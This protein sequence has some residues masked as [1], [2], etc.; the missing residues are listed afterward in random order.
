MKHPYA[1]HRAQ[2]TLNHSAPPICDGACNIGDLNANFAPDPGFWSKCAHYTRP[3]MSA[4]PE[5]LTR[6]HVRPFQPV[7]VERDKQVGVGLR[8]PMNLTGRMMVVPP[9]ALGLIHA[10]QGEQTLEQLSEAS[11]V[12]VEQL[13]QLV[14]NL[15][16]SG[17][18]WGPTFDRLEREAME[19]TRAAGAF[20]ASGSKF[21]GDTR[22]AASERIGSLLSEAEDA[23][24]GTGVLGIIAPHLDLERGGANYAAAYKVVAG[25]ARPDRV[26]VLGT[27]HFGLGDGVVATRL[28]QDSPF[29]IIPSDPAIAGLLERALGDRL[30][31][32]EA[33]FLGE[34]SVQ[35]HI[36]WIAHT[37]PG[38]P[39]F[40]ALVPDPMRAMIADDGAR[41]SFAEF[42]AALRDAIASVSG[43]TLVVS[44][45]DLS[46]VGPAFGD[47]GPVGAQVRKQVE[48]IDR[49]LLAEYASGDV[50]AF[51]QSV[52]GAGNATRWCSVG[53]M[54]V[55]LSATEGTP[56][57]IQ[58]GQ[59]PES[60]DPQGTALITSAAMALMA[61]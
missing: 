58:Y 16:E 5:H 45:A 32:D 44:S 57:L 61:D 60:L 59:S 8:D 38:V 53:N 47:P 6:P 31:K 50:E 15:D 7:G 26:I 22:E 39:V 2:G 54:A 14:S 4:A 34:H 52:R 12:P 49:G 36:P 33:D 41:A 42:R 17:L 46:H 24:L 11:K 9:Q 1:H 29:G 20:P 3:A 35:F 23:E 30:F 51:I 43:R 21:A 18:L 40:A 13:Q 27:N 10:L 25:A 48:E 37:L 19:R 55:A 28:G 56:E